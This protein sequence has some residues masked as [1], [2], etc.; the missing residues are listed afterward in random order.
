MARIAVLIGP[1]FEDSEYAQPAK[2]LRDA[3]HELTHVGIAQGEVKG[4]N[5]K[6]TA[7]IDLL[8]QRAKAADFDALFIPGGHSPDNI[9]KDKDVVRLAKEMLE[10]GKPVLAI[11]HGPQVL[12]SAGMVRG[13]TMTAWQTVQK[14]LE[15][16]G[17]I[18]HDEKVV[19]DGNLVTSRKPDDIPFFIDASLEKLGS[20]K[21]R[22]RGVAGAP[23]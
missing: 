10:S 6:A 7:T 22:A 8:A 15:L 21:E 1:E 11:C 23:A 19:A 16:A 13:R 4:K 9:R 17:A 18:V 5:G 12:L 3:G 20:G 2:A 14:D